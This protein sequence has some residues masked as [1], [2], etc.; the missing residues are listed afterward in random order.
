LSAKHLVYLSLGDITDSAYEAIVDCMS[1]LTCL[2][3]LIVQLQLPS[4]RIHPYRPPTTRTVLPVLTSLKFQGLMEHLDHLFSRINAPLLEFF[5]IFFFFPVGFDHLQLFP[6]I[7]LTKMF[8]GF[9]HAHMEFGDELLDVMLS[10]QK[11]TTGGRLLMLSTEWTDFGW[12]LGSLTQ[13]CHPPPHPYFT[14]IFQD[15]SLPPWTK[16][17][18]ITP[19]LELLRVFTA[20]ENLYLSKGLVRCIAPTLQ[21]LAGGGETEVLPAL[22]SILIE[23]PQTSEAGIVQNLVGRFVAA[24][25]LSGRPVA[26][27]FG[28]WY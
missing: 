10:S 23:I 9:N 7:G 17:M 24:R 14:N 6:L 5:D 25:E 12:D 28:Q 19:W 13:A 11:I 3:T 22:Q 26:V 2:E 15:Q 1:S 16:Y 21:E 18:G 20:V 8:E 27:N 4:S